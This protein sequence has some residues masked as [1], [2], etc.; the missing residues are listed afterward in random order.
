MVALGSR[1]VDNGSLVVATSALVVIVGAFLGWFTVPVG[2]TLG[3]I[4]G[5][6]LFENGS[7]AFN[8]L[9][10]VLLATVVTVLSLFLPDEEG[11]NVATA[12][13][14][15]GIELVAVAFVVVPDVALGPGIEAGRDVSL[16]S[17]GLGVF[18]TLLG[19]LGILLG[20]YLSYRN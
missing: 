16:S 12:V 19:G 11:V 2:D 13:A 15:L 18:V 1:P 10:T 6:D 5:I 7:L 3:S 14:G 17:I 8:G 20:G 4:Q 9:V